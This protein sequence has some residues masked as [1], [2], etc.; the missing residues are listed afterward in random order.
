M[1]LLDKKKKNRMHLLGNLDDEA[2]V[3][4]QS[5]L[6]CG[7]YLFCQFRIILLAMNIH[8]YGYDY[9]RVLYL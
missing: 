4:D 3:R 8:L 5:P 9:S 2:I 7:L 1:H 6:P